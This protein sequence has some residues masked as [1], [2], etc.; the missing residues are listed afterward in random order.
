MSVGLCD[1]IYS[2][3]RT[4]GGRAHRHRPPPARFA[5]DMTCGI[6]ERTQ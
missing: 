4:L 3:G 5:G 6:G 1:V 2:Q